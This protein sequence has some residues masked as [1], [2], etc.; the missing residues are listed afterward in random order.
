MNKKN[1]WFLATGVLSILG[2]VGV[3]IGAIV[4]LS[5]IGMIPPEGIEITTPEGTTEILPYATLTSIFIILAIV[6]V[7]ILA[8]LIFNAVVFLKNR[9]K[10]YEELHEHSGLIITAIVL[11]F[12]AGGVVCGILGLVGYTSKPAEETVSNAST[13]VTQTEETNV[14]AKLKELKELKDSGVISDE[15]YEAKRKDILDKM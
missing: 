8:V 7:V 2:A 12:I 4:I 10:T 1:S 9:S 14:S 5:M 11:S 6:L 13:I 3:G 15:E